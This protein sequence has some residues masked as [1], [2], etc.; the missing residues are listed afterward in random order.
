LHQDWLRLFPGDKRLMILL[1]LRLLSVI[2][3]KCRFARQLLLLSCVLLK[4]G[5]NGLSHG[6]QLLIFLLEE[7]VDA[8]ELVGRRLVEAGLVLSRLPVS[9]F[10]LKCRVWTWL[11]NEA[12]LC[13]WLRWYMMQLILLL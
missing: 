2:I 8:G 11:L 4:L 3:V 9:C 12:K 10:I 6:L 1:S 7:G 13:T 5:S